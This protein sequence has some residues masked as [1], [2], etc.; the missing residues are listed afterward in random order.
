MT[1]V[2]MDLVDHGQVCLLLSFF[3]ICLPPGFL[4]VLG[5][6]EGWYYLQHLAR[7]WSSREGSDMWL[8]YADLITI[9]H[10]DG[11]TVRCVD[12]RFI[13]VPYKYAASSGIWTWNLTHIIQH[14]T[15]V[16][17]YF[18]P[19]GHQGQFTQ[20]LYDLYKFLINPWHRRI[21]FDF[22]YAAELSYM[23]TLRSWHF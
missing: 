4:P 9:A 22:P 11:V 7:L 21:S 15:A 10:R 18:R 16:T 5:S 20:F 13:M 1:P 12:G 6:T 2:C 17:S 19:L 3:L 14:L 8:L 23:L